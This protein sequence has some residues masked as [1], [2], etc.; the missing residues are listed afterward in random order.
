MNFL[1]GSCLILFAISLASKCRELLST[2][3]DQDQD[4]GLLAL[5]GPGQEQRG[6]ML[7]WNACRGRHSYNR[8]R[9][10]QENEPFTSPGAAPV[11]AEDT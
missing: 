8:D 5:I 9:T 10:I 3:E 1:V 7:S 2:P 11:D 6:A 4:M